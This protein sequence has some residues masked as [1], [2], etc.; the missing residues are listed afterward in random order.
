[1]LNKCFFVIAFLSLGV[2]CYSQTIQIIDFK[3]LKASYVTNSDTTYIVNFFASWCSPCLKEIPEFINVSNETTNEKI[4]LIFVSL[5]AI[6]SCEESLIPLVKKYQIKGN[7]F[8]L[9]EGNSTEWINFVNPDW[10]G[11]IP[12]TLIINSKTRLNKFVEGPI[13]SSKLKK[14]IK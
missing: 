13:T 5:D 11:A 8:V 3:T 14:I 4:K 6:K 10:S 7:V 9:D 1:M 12:S 2:K